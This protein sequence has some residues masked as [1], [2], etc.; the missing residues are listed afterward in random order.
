[1]DIVTQL[2]NIFAFL[3]FMG[4]ISLGYAEVKRQRNGKSGDD[5][6]QYLIAEHERH[7]MNITRIDQRLSA[8][9]QRLDEIWQ[10]LAKGR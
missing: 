3:A 8:I 4:V 1:M 10:F 9:E 7:C 5:R 6:I 2:D